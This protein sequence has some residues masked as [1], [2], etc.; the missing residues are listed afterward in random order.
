[1]QG[2]PPKRRIMKF[3]VPFIEDTFLITRNNVAASYTNM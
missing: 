2:A 3:A 1:M